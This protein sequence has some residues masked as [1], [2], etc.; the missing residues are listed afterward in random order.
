MHSLG[1]LHQETKA[2]HQGT[3]PP[4]PDSHSTHSSS[5]G[6]MEN[7]AY[8]AAHG[9]LSRIP[10]REASRSEREV[11]RPGPRSGWTGPRWDF[12]SQVLPTA[13][14]VFDLLG[15]SGEE[16]PAPLTQQLT[17]FHPSYP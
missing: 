12:R 4:L 16:R 11:G 1:F 17:S 7:A 6:L 2:Q 8:P 3:P 9:A 13:L 15:I 5:Q 14:L 10:A